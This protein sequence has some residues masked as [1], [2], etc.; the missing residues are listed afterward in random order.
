MAGFR[1][2]RADNAGWV[3]DAGVEA[4]ALD[5]FEDIA[6]GFGFGLG[7]FAFDFSGV[8]IGDFGDDGAVWEF[9]KGM[10]AVDVDEFGVDFKGFLDNVS[11]AEDVDLIDGWVGF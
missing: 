7:V 9:R 1:I 3:D 6:G 2:V 5:G 10:D 8:K 11:G 4:A